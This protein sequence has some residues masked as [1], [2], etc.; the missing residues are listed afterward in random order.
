MREDGCVG[1]GGN[2]GELTSLQASNGL[3][4][5]LGF[6]S[7]GYD[8]GNGAAS[9]AVAVHSLSHGVLSFVDFWL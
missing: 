2:C 4:F 8:R 3:I 6:I 9:C 5:T 7:L 1:M